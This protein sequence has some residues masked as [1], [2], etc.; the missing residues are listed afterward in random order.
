MFL[1]AVFVE[2]GSVHVVDIEIEPVPSG[3]PVVKD[4]G[5]HDIVG[6]DGVKALK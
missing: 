2:P 3:D 6:S 1:C 4:A 5:F